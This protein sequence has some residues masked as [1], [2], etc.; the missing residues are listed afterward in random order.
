MKLTILTKLTNEHNEFSFS[1][2]APPLLAADPAG[3]AYW[4]GAELKAYG[5]KLAPK[6]NPLKVATEQLGKLGNHSTMLAYREADGEAEL[7]ERQ[8]DIFIVQA[9]AATLV[10]GGKVV[11]RP[12][13][14]ARA[15]SAALHRGRR[16]A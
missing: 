9:G 1:Y 16:E 6:M 10:V 3:F 15:R 11:G 2:C 8:A 5:K 14:R 7:H 12:V 4:S 13:H